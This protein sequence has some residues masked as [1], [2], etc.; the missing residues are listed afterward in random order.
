M[1]LLPWL[2]LVLLVLEFSLSDD[3]PAAGVRRMFVGVGLGLLAFTGIAALF[4]PHVA[5]PANLLIAAG[6]LIYLLIHGGL[7]RLFWKW[8]KSEPRMARAGNRHTAQGVFFYEGGPS[9]PV[10]WTDYLYTLVLG[11]GM[12][13]SATAAI[14]E[15]V[16][17][18]G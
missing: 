7:R 16:Q 11:L 3:L 4:Y 5:G 12:L 6:P 14:R 17:R 9:R 8:R 15:I 13:F 2:V 1:W 18:S 10:S